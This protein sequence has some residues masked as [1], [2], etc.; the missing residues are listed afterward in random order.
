MKLKEG[1]AEVRTQLYFPGYKQHPIPTTVQ[2]SG[3]DLTI[4]TSLPEGIARA[5]LELMATNDI[6]GLI[7]EINGANP[8]LTVFKPDG[9][10]LEKA[11]VIASEIQDLL[12]VQKTLKDTFHHRELDGGPTAALKHPLYIQAQIRIDELREDLTILI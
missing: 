9:L 7:F 3:N 10:N 2:Q 12:L 4:K 6:R 1:E 11:A 8:M 5:Y